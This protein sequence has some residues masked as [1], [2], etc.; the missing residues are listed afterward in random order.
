MAGAKPRSVFTRS[1]KYQYLLVLLGILTACQKPT[2]DPLN[3]AV[4]LLPLIRGDDYWKSQAQQAVVDEL[5]RER[6]TKRAEDILAEIPGY[7]RALARLDG[8]EVL[9]RM[10]KFDE[11][12]RQL[13][14]LGSLPREGAAQQS[15]EIM[16]RLFSLGEAA[17]YGPQALAAVEKAGIAVPPMFQNLSKETF[18]TAGSEKSSVDPLG[19]EGRKFLAPAAKGSKQKAPEKSKAGSI[20]EAPEGGGKLQARMKISSGGDALLARAEGLLA[21]GEREKAKDL[22]QPPLQEAQGYRLA[23]VGTR[24]ELLRLAWLAGLEKPVEAQ[25]DELV[26]LTRSQPAAL[27]TSYGYW[28]KVVRLLATASRQEQAVALAAEASERIREALPPFFQTQALA[29]LGTG[30]YQAGLKEQA[31][32]LWREALAVAAKVSNPRSQAWGALQVSLAAVRSG[33]SFTPEELEQIGRIEKALPEAF[34]RI[35]Q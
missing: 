10:G 11:A 5:F 23:N 25:L 29:E 27:E 14:S 6:Q 31:R 2:T 24:A 16:G 7:R 9:I 19:E 4:A 33:A 13:E 22:L 32:E 18:M 34:V 15:W 21:R 35:G 12:G 1:M 30:L 26:Q 28:G 8:V 3:R 20:Q 17:G